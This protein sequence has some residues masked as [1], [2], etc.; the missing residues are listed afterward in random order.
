[1]ALTSRNSALHLVATATAAFAFVLL[2]LGGLVTA[3]NSGLGC[4]AEWPLC[5]SAFVPPI[6]DVHAWIEAGHRLMAAIVS[7]GVAACA[8]LAWRARRGPAP[9]SV[10]AWRLALVACGLILLEILLGMA[11][12]LLSLP[13]WVVAVHMA[14]AATLVG[15]LAGLA[16]A[17]GARSLRT[18]AQHARGRAGHRAT[19]QR[20]A[21]RRGRC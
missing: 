8:V 19:A 20:R 21:H 7:V 6:G 9:A 11:T 5:Q 14:D 15:V 17:T 4:G 2:A 10:A 13:A 3:S 1:M 18:A 16:R 12:V